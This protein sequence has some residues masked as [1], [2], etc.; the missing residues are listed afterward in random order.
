MPA[1]R[2]DDDGDVTCEE[3]AGT[4]SFH[5]ATN[6]IH[7]FW[8]HSQ[9]ST[10]ISKVLRHI[11]IELSF[12]DFQSTWVENV[13]LSELQKERLDSDRDVATSIGPTRTSHY[14]PDLSRPSAES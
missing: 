9:A 5:T 3:S 2:Y 13:D 10:T 11:L 12:P 1:W 14:L 7:R 4:I 6:T 8:R